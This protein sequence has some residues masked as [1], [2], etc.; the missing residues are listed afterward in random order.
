MVQ[1]VQNCKQKLSLSD[2]TVKAN[3]SNE[4]I[5]SCCQRLLPLGS[6]S[7]DLNLKEHYLSLTNSYSVSSDGVLK[8]P[9]DFAI[10]SSNS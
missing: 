2:L 4:Q 8:I 10:T 1:A 5:K 3:V 9:W 6:G 7:E